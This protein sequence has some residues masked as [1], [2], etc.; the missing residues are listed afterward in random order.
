M[1]YILGQK[2][3]RWQRVER[4]LTS[5]GYTLYFMSFFSGKFAREKSTQSAGYTQNCKSEAIPGTAY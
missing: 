4:Q 2:I 1:K 5:R 3:K